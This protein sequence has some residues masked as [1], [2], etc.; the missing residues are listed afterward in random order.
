MKTINLKTTETYKSIPAGFTWDNIPPFSIITGVNG[1]GKTQLLEILKGTDN[2]GMAL[3]V[4]AE[5]T[6]EDSMTATLVLPSPQTR[7]NNITGLLSYFQNTANRLGNLAQWK[8]N[9]KEWENHIS[10]WIEPQLK[11]DIPTEKKYQLT[12]ERTSLLENIKSYK[13]MVRDNTI[14]AYE[15]ELDAISKKLSIPIENLTEADIRRYANPYFNDFSD[16]EDLERY[17]KQEHD[18]FKENLAIAVGRNDFE[19]VKT[20]AAQEKPYQ[21]INRLFK[22]YGFTY[23]EMLDP[24]PELKER[25]GEIR[26]EGKNGEIIDY[27]ALSSGE[28]MIVMFIAL[29]LGRNISGNRINTLILDE[30]D[31]HLHPT[32]SKMMVEILHELSMPK[33]LGGGDIRVII[34]THSPST[35][36]FAPEGALFVIEKNHECKKVRETC[37]SE[38]INILSDG[39]LTYDKAVKQFSLAIN[40]NK[41]VIVFVE[42]KTDILHLNRANELL[43]YNLPFEIIDMHDAGALANFIKSTPSKIFPG[44]KLIALFDADTEGF[45]SYGSIT[46]DSQSIHLAKIITAIQCE[47][48]SFAMTLVA[49]AQINKYCPI[50]FLYPLEYLRT[51]NMLEK[52]NFQEYQNL[53]KASSLEEATNL[54][55]EYDKETGLKPFKANDS[56]KDAFSQICALETESK[57]FDNF[58]P[59]LEVI[60]QIIEYK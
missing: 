56:N 1:A 45:K 49:P 50:E 42:G 23:F 11:Q 29:S 36:A 13:Q 44:K 35:V 59:T 54:N 48:N 16:I 22:K 32:M 51:H 37:A 38:A 40:S 24:F 27:N 5:I 58:K 26:F 19:K 34:T 9:I 30:P 46:G 20:L 47:N 7:G 43:G 8:N 15:E 53:Y 2:N 21:S 6:D 33:E 28:Q 10:T 55:N 31:A 52:R 12:S 25:N 41:D 18:E 39:I 17:I 57:L 60:K 4:S 14:F 3:Y